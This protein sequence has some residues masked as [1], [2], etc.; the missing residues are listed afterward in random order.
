[1]A[2]ESKQPAVTS[3][4]NPDTPLLGENGKPLSKNQLKKL[5]KGKVRSLSL[6]YSVLVDNDTYI[7]SRSSFSF[8]QGQ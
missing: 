8:V 5:A 7:N 2:E 6:F 1:M 3:E 4:A